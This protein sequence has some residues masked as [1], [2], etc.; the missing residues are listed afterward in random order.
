MLG[1]VHRWLLKKWCERYL[2]Y[3]QGSE[4][5]CLIANFRHREGMEQKDLSLIHI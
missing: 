5:R 2:V 3:E 1:G 4:C